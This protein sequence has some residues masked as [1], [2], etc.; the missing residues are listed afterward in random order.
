MNILLV[1]CDALRYDHV[2]EEYMPNL[3]KLV[4]RG[5]SFRFCL[6]MGVNTLGSIPYILCS[7]NIGKVEENSLEL[8]ESNFI[9]PLR[10]AGYTTAAI[11]SNILLTQRLSFKQMFD[12]EVDLLSR[13]VGERKMAL[14]NALRKTGIWKRTRNLRAKVREEANAYRRAEATVE[15][16]QSWIEEHDGPWFLWAHLMDTHIPY[17]PEGYE[18]FVSYERMKEVNERILRNIHGGL[19]LTEEDK[20][21]AM[22]LYGEEVRYMDRWLA[23]FIK[24][25]S[26]ETL[27]IVTSDH[28]DE[29]GEY[30]AYSHSWKTHGRIPQLLHVPLIFIGPGVQAQVLDDYVCHLDIAPTILDFAGL[31]EKIGYGKSLR[32]ILGGGS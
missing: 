4:E 9:K 7:K 32:P 27:I 6:S 28:G 25:Q 29:F 31:D 10:T 18:D 30:G 14:R 21:E 22:I 13:K 26:E 12:F 1:V 16:C 19:E 23:Y 20:K 11:H 2:N 17:W 8:L 3:M 5:S 24:E 15:A